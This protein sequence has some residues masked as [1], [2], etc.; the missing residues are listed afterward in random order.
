MLSPDTDK[1][2]GYEVEKLMPPVLLWYCM[3]GKVDI[4]MACIRGQ[5]LDK[6][7]AA[8]KIKKKKKI[9]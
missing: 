9:S 8:Q 7:L 4:F 3:I 1:T 6:P 2:P 5:H